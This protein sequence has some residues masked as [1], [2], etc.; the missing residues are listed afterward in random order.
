MCAAQEME[1][2]R[3]RTMAWDLQVLCPP[4]AQAAPQPRGSLFINYTSQGSYL[5][6]WQ[7]W[8]I[9]VESWDLPGFEDS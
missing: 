1:G 5:K 2:W 9:P 3:H 4:T 8:A 6:K 7:T